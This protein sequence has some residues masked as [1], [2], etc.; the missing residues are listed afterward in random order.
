MG[1]Q[2]SRS[3]T[4][5]LRHR[6]E[7][8][9]KYSRSHRQFET[10]YFGARPNRLLIYDK[11]GELAN[12]HK[13]IVRKQERLREP[14]VA[15]EEF[16]GYP[17]LGIALTRIERELSG[18]RIPLQ[19]ATL[20]K[21]K[22]G[23]TKFNPFDQLEFLDTDVESAV[24]T[25]S[26]GASEYLKLEGF[27]QSANVR[28]RGVSKRL[29]E[30]RVLSVGECH[31]VI[32]QLVEEPFRTMVILDMATGLRCSELLA[33]KWCDIEWEQL[34]MLVRRAIVDGTVDEVKTK[35]SKAGLPLDPTLTEIL[36][37][38]KMK[39]QFRADSDWIFA[40]P[41]QAGAF[42]Y[43]PWGVQQRR[44]RPAGQ[45]AGLGNRIGW[46]TFRHTFASMLRSNGEDL[47]VQQ[48]LLRHADVRTTINVYTQAL[49]DDKR[50]AQ[51]KVVRMVL[52]ETRERSRSVAP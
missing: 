50:R 2:L 19:I 35:Y 8:G 52:P 20:S 14:R 16:C 11:I 37:N 13:Q 30:P 46:H 47:K 44:I 23:G 12:Q 40:S 25:D 51:S 38:W 29:R 45:R 9:L 33:L 32:D 27:R 43:A 15:F 26:V 22:H 42:P 1:W 21:L 48:E 3:R 7:F 28:V 49:S 4:A 10:L 31:R 39:T 17:R 24:P 41:F 36:W 6:E 34:G 5:L 18:S